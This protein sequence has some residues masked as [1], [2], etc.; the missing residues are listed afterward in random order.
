MD[1][2]QMQQLVWL[3]QQLQT[4]LRIPEAQ[5][6][7]QTAGRRFPTATFRGQLLSGLGG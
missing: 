4:R 1:K 5:V 7:V 2:P 6:R 3:V